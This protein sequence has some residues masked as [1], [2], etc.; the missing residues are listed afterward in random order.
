MKINNTLTAINLP[1][2]HIVNINTEHKS[3]LQDTSREK[4]AFS[5]IYVTLFGKTKSLA[6]SKKGCVRGL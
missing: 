1:F 5:G 2:I 4:S 6:E 3:P